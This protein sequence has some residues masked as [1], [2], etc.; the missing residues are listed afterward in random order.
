M[1]NHYGDQ[2]KR[3]SGHWRRNAIDVQTV[4][5][6]FSAANNYSRSKNVN[7]LT[8]LRHMRDYLQQS[9]LTNVGTMLNQR[10]FSGSSKSVDLA[11]P[12]QL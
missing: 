4:H 7:M 10:P 9:C 11:G 6:R 12:G 2:L 8:S 5:K 1:V 3:V